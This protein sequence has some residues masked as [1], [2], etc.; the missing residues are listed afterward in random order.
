MGS[1][2]P[3]QPGPHKEGCGEAPEER[4]G[5]SWGAGPPTRGQV[6]IRAEA[7]A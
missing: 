2:L 3:F 1:R 7:K 4:E 6:G 5:H